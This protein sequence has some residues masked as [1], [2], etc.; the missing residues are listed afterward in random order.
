M[1]ISK[2]TIKYIKTLHLKK[3]RQKYNNFIAEGEKIVGELLQQT[4]YPVTEVFATPDWL[5]AHLPELTRRGIAATPISEAELGAITQ[6]S[7]PNKVLA[8]VGY[9]PTTPPTN[10]ADNW[11]IYLAGLQDPGNVGT[12]LRIA[13]WFAIPRVVAGPGTV[14]LYNSKT[15]QATMGAFLRVQWLTADLPDVLAQAPNLPVWSADMGGHDVFS[16]AAPTAGILVIGNE[17]QG[18]PEAVRLL[19]TQTIAITAPPG[20]GAESLNAAVATGILCA[21]LRRG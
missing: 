4:V 5:G 18:I 2:N 15:L 20:S 3:F 12:I 13:D 16:L 21:A 7:T 19:T 17:G 9:P 11:T 6:L 14:D 1:A 10:W 8:L